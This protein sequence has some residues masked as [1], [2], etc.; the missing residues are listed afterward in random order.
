MIRDPGADQVCASS[1]LTDLRSDPLVESLRELV[2][3]GT[4]GGGSFAHWLPP[5]A[6]VPPTDRLHVL[7][8]CKRKAA[9]IS[10]A[11]V[12][13][14]VGLPAAEPKGLTSGGRA[15]PPGFTGSVSYQGTRVAVVLASQDLV[16]S[17]GVDIESRHGADELMAVSGLAGPGEL[18]PMLGSE[19]AVIL[20]SAKEAV[21]KAS[22]P[23]LGF[24]PGLG[25]VTVSWSDVR[26]HRLDGIARVA[27]IAL[28]LRCSTSVAGFVG[29]AALLGVSGG[30]RLR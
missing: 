17:I 18:P 21:F 14:S 15:W 27:G 10:L 30:A 29:T 7:G 9:R 5:P 19:G 4:V 20:F 25:D 8:Q 3:E 1:G 11:A 12:A 6:K 2:P 13:G 16:E 24:R 22:C 28:E 26:P 23:I